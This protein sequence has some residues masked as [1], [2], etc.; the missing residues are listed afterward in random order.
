ML[1]LFFLSYKC[2]ALLY[3]GLK[4]PQH[5][6]YKDRTCTILLICLISWLLKIKKL[7]K[8]GP[9]ITNQSSHYSIY[10]IT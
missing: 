5:M 9:T 10:S 7:A 2:E 6:F 8:I 4:W 1:I 3:P